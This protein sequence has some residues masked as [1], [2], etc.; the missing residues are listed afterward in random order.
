MDDDGSMIDEY[1][2]AAGT[3]RTFRLAVYGGGQFLE[4]VERRDGAW[5]G[6]RFAALF[7][8]TAAWGSARTWVMC[9]Y[10]TRSHPA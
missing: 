5:A 7:E 3:V 10:R 2:D 9:A 8:A 6:L 4:A 1:L